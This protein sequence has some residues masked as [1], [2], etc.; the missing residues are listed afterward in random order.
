MTKIEQVADCKIK[1][2]RDVYHDEN[3]NDI[4]DN[5]IN[6][7]TS[8][9]IEVLASNPYDNILGFSVNTID[10]SV[11]SESIYNGYNKFFNTINFSTPENVSIDDLY[12]LTI[13]PNI[14]RS[15]IL[16]VL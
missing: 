2:H 6:E 11:I 16:V 14:D 10:Q 7:F 3:L 13:L 15:N 1:L 4:V 9:N 12:N 5:I 8:H